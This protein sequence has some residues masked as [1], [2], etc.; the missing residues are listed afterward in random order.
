[1]CMYQFT[2]EYG[3]TTTLKGVYQSE[4]WHEQAQPQGLSECCEVMTVCRRS[5]LVKRV[6]IDGTQAA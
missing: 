3:N 2:V 6:L 5:A 4:D 1:M